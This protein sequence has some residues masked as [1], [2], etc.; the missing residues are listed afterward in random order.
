MKCNLKGFKMGASILKYKS[1][2]VH[3]LIRVR[4][5]EPGRCRGSCAA[6]GTAMKLQV[7]LSPQ[8]YAKKLCCTGGNQI[9]SAQN[10]EVGMAIALSIQLQFPF[11]FNALLSALSRRL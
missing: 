11:D 8:R 3:K 9:M 6:E 7:H 10:K 2:S 1:D 5:A 4:G